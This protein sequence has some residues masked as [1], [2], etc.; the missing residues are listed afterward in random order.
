M[1]ASLAKKVVSWEIDKRKPEM[2][3]LPLLGLDGDHTDAGATLG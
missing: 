2:I 3:Q 1:L